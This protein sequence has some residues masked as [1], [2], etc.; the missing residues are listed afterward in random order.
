MRA[1]DTHNPWHPQRKKQRPR[2]TLWVPRKSRR[3]RSKSSDTSLCLRGQIQLLLTIAC[4]V[5]L[6]R[7]VFW[8]LYSRHPTEGVPGPQFP[9]FLSQRCPCPSG[10]I[11]ILFTLTFTH[12]RVVFRNTHRWDLQTETN[13]SINNYKHQPNSLKTREVTSVWKCRQ[14]GGSSR[15]ELVYNHHVYNESLKF[16]LS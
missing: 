7:L 10:G 8:N 5:H 6:C 16:L 11:W 9:Q 1:E 4:C 14:H 2:D 15:W 12:D 13:G 3:Q